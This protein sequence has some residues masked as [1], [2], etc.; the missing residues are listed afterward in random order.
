[1]KTYIARLDEE[2]KSGSMD[3]PQIKVT[4]HLNIG[5]GFF[6][7]KF[8]ALNDKFGFF[9]TPTLGFEYGNSES[10]TK[11]NFESSIQEGR[12]DQFYLSS[13]LGVYYFIS[14]RFSVESYLASI[15]ISKKFNKE[16]N[17]G[18]NN[19]SDFYRSSETNDFNFHF[20]N[21]LSLDQIIVINYYF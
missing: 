6:W 18:T 13:G 12:S 5:A 10:E 19:G 2:N 11:N 21:E 4:E 1:M 16:L 8:W 14:P 15:R 20:I 9:A 17:I 7:K 3:N